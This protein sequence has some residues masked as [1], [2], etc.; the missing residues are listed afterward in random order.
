LCI[1]KVCDLANKYRTG[2]IVVWYGSDGENCIRECNLHGSLLGIAGI[3]WRFLGNGFRIYTVSGR[4]FSICFQDREPVLYEDLSE[5]CRITM[6]PEDEF[7]APGHEPRVFGVV[8]S[9]NSLV[10]FVCYTIVAPKELCYKSSIPG[11]LSAHRLYQNEAAEF[12]RVLIDKIKTL[13]TRHDL[14]MLLYLTSGDYASPAGI[15]WDVIDYA[16]QEASGEDS[17]N[18]SDMN[19][20]FSRLLMALSESFNELAIYDVTTINPV[21]FEDWKTYKSCI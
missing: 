20:F 5:A 6:M 13:L 1:R 18:W 19:I 10:D 3:V 9:G 11:Y 2:G 21:A 8:G 12:E 4:L 15:L 14:C 7:P 16:Q 17:A